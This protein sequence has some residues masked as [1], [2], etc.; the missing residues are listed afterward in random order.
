MRSEQQHIDDFFRNKEEEWMPDTNQLGAHWQQL[1]ALLTK[2]VVTPPGKKFRLQSSRRIIK[3]M[4]G[5]AVVTV[6]T[7]VTVNTIKNKK[8]TSSIPKTQQVVK[9]EQPAAHK[10]T[11]ATTT[12]PATAPRKTTDEKETSLPVT[13]KKAVENPV[14]VQQRPVKSAPAGA[15]NT[16]NV[17]VKKP[18]AARLLAEFYQ[19]F[20][21]KAQ[22]FSIQANRDTTLSGKEGTKLAI[23]ANSFANK[24][25]VIRNGTIRIVL[26]EYYTYDDI[27]AAKLNTTSNGEQLVSGGML[28]IKAQS[29]NEEVQLA[30]TKV[31]KVSMPT[32]NYDSRMQLFTGAALTPI[33]NLE[34]GRD[35]T[36]YEMA[37]IAG[38][39]VINW[40][41]ADRTKTIVN[42]HKK[43]NITVTDL[44]ID[45]K[46]VT[47]GKK[48]TAK[49]LVAD[50]FELSDKEIKEQLKKRYGDYYDKIKIRRVNKYKH[51]DVIDSTVMDYKVAARLKLITKEDSIRFAKQFTQKD[52]LVLVSKKKDDIT[53]YEF[54]V[55]TLGWINCDR[56]LND[57]RP[58]VNF[59]LNLGERCNA[60]DF[61]SQL[62]FVNYKSVMNAVYSG[63]KISFLNIPVNE[64][65]YLISVGVKDGKVVHTIHRAI[66]SKETINL[67]FEESSPVEFRKK[68]ET[69]LVFQ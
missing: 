14:T 47:Y 3:F 22:E 61:I 31:I 7:F 28:N 9:R 55:P 24:A 1:S 39:Q 43:Q 37:G 46:R 57:P 4:G 30:P 53:A 45:P 64:P 10:R 2:P 17:P 41:A 21:K 35:Y 20:E 36:A 19:T 67:N 62:V 16:T 15:P 38:G 40:V 33:A 54:T 27:V 68:L 42:N 63:N 60:G 48:T 66:T 6:L 13:K 69:L 26:T 50:D 59:T 32:K 18:S 11:T 65:V 56:F 5:F 34:P 58:K 8:T 44:S 12:V 49:F 25:G 23:A 51:E 29:Q 52:S